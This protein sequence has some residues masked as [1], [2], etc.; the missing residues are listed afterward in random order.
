MNSGDEK[1]SNF[2]LIFDRFLGQ[3]GKIRDRT[4]KSGYVRSLDGREH[5]S[6]A[7]TGL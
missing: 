7:Q 3:V 2:Y 1:K 6:I 4:T 5:S